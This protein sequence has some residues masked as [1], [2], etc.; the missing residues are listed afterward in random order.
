MFYYYCSVRIQVDIPPW[1]ISWCI[2]W[3]SF[4]KWDEL[5]YCSAQSNFCWHYIILQKK[6]IPKEIIFLSKNI[7]VTRVFLEPFFLDFNISVV[8]SDNESQA[9]NI[10]INSVQ[11]SPISGFEALSA[12]FILRRLKSTTL[13]VYYDVFGVVVKLQ[14]LLMRSTQ[15]VVDI[16]NSFAT[17]RSFVPPKVIIIILSFSRLY[18]P[19]S[20]MSVVE[21]WECFRKC[22]SGP[23]WESNPGPLKPKSCVR[24]PSILHIVL[25]CNTL[26]SNFLDFFRIFSSVAIYRFSLLAIFPI[27]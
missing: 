19:L 6:R 4:S 20:F 15:K 11:F 18:N 7:S 26:I 24:S 17:R 22:H 1:H 12:H 2:K 21:R 9:H 14:M 27:N 25:A 8:L 5:L 3:E 23:G 13:N 10:S 16:T